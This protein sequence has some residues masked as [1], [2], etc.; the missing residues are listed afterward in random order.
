M[1]IKSI[2]DRFKIKKTITNI[3]VCP[4]KTTYENKEE[5]DCSSINIVNDNKLKDIHIKKQSWDEQ[6]FLHYS[7]FTFISHNKLILDL[8]ME[9]LAKDFSDVTEFNPKDKF[10]ELFV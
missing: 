9:E 6:Y 5:I 2:N 1:I 10:P 3:E 4:N 7:I 8:L